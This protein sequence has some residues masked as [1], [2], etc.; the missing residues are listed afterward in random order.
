MK[1]F[2]FFDT[3]E[4]IEA[5]DKAE[6]RQLSKAGAFVRRRARSSIRKRKGIS[7]PGKPPTNQTGR[8]KSSILFGYDRNASSVVIGPSFSFGGSEVPQLIEF[9]GFAKLDGEQVYYE[10][11]PTMLPALEKE[12]PNFPSLFLNSVVK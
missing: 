5:L 10:A 2:A 9:G 12:V 7:K 3:K 11:R 4:V 8:Y 6:A 1:T